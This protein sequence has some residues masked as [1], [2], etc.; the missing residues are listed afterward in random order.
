[1]KIVHA[2]KPWNLEPDF[3]KWIDRETGLTCAI[4]RHDEMGHLCGY[5]KVPHSNLRKRMIV[6]SRIPAGIDLHGKLQCCDAASLREIVNLRVHGGITFS[7]RFVRARYVGMHR[8]YWIGFDCTHCYDLSPKMD[9]F[10]QERGLPPSGGIYRDFAYVT[11]ECADLAK[12]LRAV[13]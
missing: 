1:M 9:A 10:M 13:L 8:G 6:R 3:K 2:E 12:Q 5:V 7:G 4:I 11:Q